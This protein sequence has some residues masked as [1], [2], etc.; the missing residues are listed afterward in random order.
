MGILVVEVFE[1]EEDEISREGREGG[2]EVEEHEGGV[3]VFGSCDET[4]SFNVKNV[5]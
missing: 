4:L 1:G 5:V 2:P 3:G